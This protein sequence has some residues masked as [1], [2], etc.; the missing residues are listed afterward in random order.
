[1][2]FTAVMKELWWLWLLLFLLSIFIQLAACA[3]G[4]QS[5]TTTP[6]AVA[7]D[8]PPAATD[9]PAD[10]PLATTTYDFA[11]QPPINSGC[12]PSADKAWAP[13][14]SI[15]ITVPLASDGAT[16]ITADE[17]MDFICPLGTFNH[18]TFYT[19]GDTITD[20]EIDLHFPGFL[21]TSTPDGFD[22]DIQEAEAWVASASP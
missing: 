11:F 22:Y 10:P 3:G 12:G 18:A 7:A 6:Y 2:R 9:P 19:Q 17:V 5:N 4:G 16:A 13:C 1:M 15:T 20:F 21:G 8:P 14:G